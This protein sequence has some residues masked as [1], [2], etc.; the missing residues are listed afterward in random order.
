MCKILISLDDLKAFC[1][2]VRNATDND[3]LD[4]QL[5]DYCYDHD[6]YEYNISELRVALQ[7]FIAR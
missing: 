4:D 7:W 2:M 6:R 5:A 1:P 3:D